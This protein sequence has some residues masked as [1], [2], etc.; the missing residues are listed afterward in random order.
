MNLSL[1][2]MLQLAIILPILSSFAIIAAGRY[3]NLR[4]SVTITTCLI[5]IYLVVNLY[6]GLLADE[7]ISV[8]WWELLPGLNVSFDIEPLGMLFAL[9]A[10]FLWL[11]TT[12]YAIGYMRS[13]NE[14][15]QTRFYVCFAIAIGAVIGL[16]FSA[17]LFTLFIFYE[18]LTLSTYPLVTHA[19]TEKAK[20][21]GRTYLG[22]LLT[23]SIVLFLLAIVGTWFVAGTLDFKLGG[24]FSDDVSIF[25]ASALLVLFIFG[26]G[27]AAIMPFHRWL[28][29]AMVAPTPVSSLLHA[30]AVVKAGVFTVLK[31]C[32]FIFGLDLLAILPTTQFL[33][34]L[35][36]ASVLLASIVAMRQDNLKARLAY[37]TVSQLGYITIGAL[38]ATSTGVVGSSMH[39][40]MH[41]FGKITLFFCAGAILVSLHKSKISEMVGIGKQMPITMAAFFIASLS[42]IGVPPTGG[43]WSK[44]YLMMGALETEQF[45]IMMVLM[46]SSLLNIA[47]LLPIPFHAFFPNLTAFK[48]I[49]Q[50]ASKVIQEKQ[51]IDAGSDIQIKEAPLPSLIA[52]VV[53]ALGCLILFVH[54]Q[55]LFELATSV[56]TGRG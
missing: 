54:P 13:H 40:A 15:N 36:A 16:A 52:I 18:V 29:A 7:T 17:N 49:E 38:L 31:V 46:L 33:L 50:G 26:I 41:A 32:V 14:K 56:L 23:T 12:C 48:P 37:S 1:D 45:I 5:L 8:F 10:S 42:I 19:G 30:V 6:Q 25:V 43:T 21:G 39:I 35:A 24:I 9:I 3:P 20:Q 55:P 28:P 47:Y 4:E 34:Y 53:T 44:W 2:L 22:I 51:K 11:V 27:K